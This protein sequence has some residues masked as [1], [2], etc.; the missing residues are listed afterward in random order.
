MTTAYVTH[1]RYLD[2]NLPTHPE[3]AGRLRAIWEHLEKAGV[4]DKMLPLEPVEATEE[5]LLAVHDR[6]YLDYLEW[7]SGQSRMMILDQGDTYALPDSYQIA[8]L[9]A[10]GVIRAVDA[11]VSGEADN[12]L[13]LVRPPGH[14]A[15]P[16][17]A[18]G[19]CILANVA[20]AARHAQNAHGIDR[21][22]IV[23]YDVHHGN[24]TQEIFY[25]D[26]SVLYISTH[27]YP[28]Y[29]GTGAKDET[30][31]GPGRGYT[32]NIPLPAGVGD[33]GYREVYRDIL[34]PAVR[35]FKPELILVSAGFDAHWDDPL[36]MMS[37]S[38][39]GYAALTRELVEMANALCGGKIIFA[40]EG[41]YN[42]QVLGNGIL[43][44][45]HALLGRD[46]ISDPIGPS[47]S[48]RE[49]PIG[50]LIEDIQRLH[51]L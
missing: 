19:F 18:M 33:G 37:L 27:Q 43:N 6:S 21:I 42:R 51:G 29:P 40:L 41:G 5:Q 48:S 24:G 12:G 36:A 39:E 49:P 34:W 26:P 7:V 3:N 14:H 46:E 13:A 4:I 38:L 8:R 20:I 17:R 10:G 45:C 50:R 47:G 44:I 32:L 9:S 35:R 23:D 16:T 28:F 1:R 11:V 30:G 31:R 22:M 15:L 25:E 2:H